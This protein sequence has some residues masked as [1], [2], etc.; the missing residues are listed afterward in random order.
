MQH[1]FEGILGSGREKAAS[2]TRRSM[3]GRMAGAVAALFGAEAVAS[4]QSWGHPPATSAYGEEGGVNPYARREEGRLTTRT[5][6]EEGG[7]RPTYAWSEE[8]GWPWPP[9]EG[10]PTTY[11]TW[12]EG[13]W[14]R[15]PWVHPP[16]TAAACE[17]GGHRH[18]RHRP[19]VGRPTTQAAR[20]GSSAR[21]GRGR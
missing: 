18:H 9:S 7:W 13:G 17:E 14:P 20:T 10:P 15:P 5:L 3:L 2:T 11:G 4:A 21:T 16:I 12:E 19:P 8:G 1:P 6:G